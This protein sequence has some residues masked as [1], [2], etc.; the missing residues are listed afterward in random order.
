MLRI[1]RLCLNLIY[2][3]SILSIPMVYYESLDIEEMV[4]SM[5]NVA[6][7]DGELTVEE[8]NMH[9]VGYKNV[10]GARR[11]PWRIIYKARHLAKVAFHVAVVELE[12][13]SEESYKDNTLIMQLLRDNLT[14]WTSDHAVFERQDL[15]NA[16]ANTELHSSH[17]IRLRSLFNVLH[18]SGIFCK[19]YS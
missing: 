18:N 17:Q 6:K 2:H 5:K 11:G 3:D 1:Y 12:T 9:F 13:L 7:L 16:S 8:Q 10:I 15:D 14:L 4:E 19:S